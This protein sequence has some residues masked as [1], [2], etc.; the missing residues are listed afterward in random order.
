MNEETTLLFGQ[1]E[2]FA[3]EIK[4]YKIPMKFYLRFWFYNMGIGE[5][6][7]GGSLDYL[8][9]EYFKFISITEQNVYDK[10]FNNLTDSEMFKNIFLYSDEGLSSEESDYYYKRMEQLGYIFADNQLN[11]FTIGAV[12]L[13]A[14]IKFLVYEMDVKE[15][16]QLYSFNYDKPDILAPYKSFMQYAFKNGLKK[17]GLFFPEN[18]THK[19]IE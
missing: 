17:H 16:P 7:R 6:K 2:K 5:F 9:N 10:E 18:F 12:P 14:K 8:I 1:K 11:N 3:I 19:D 4:P 13:K 15:T